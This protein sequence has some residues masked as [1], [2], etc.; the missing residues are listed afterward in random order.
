MLVRNRCCLPLQ[1]CEAP[2]AHGR[3]LPAHSDPQRHE[4]AVL[5]MVHRLQRRPALAEN[6]VVQILR[7]V[8]P[9]V[10]SR[11]AAR[12]RRI[13]VLPRA[14]AYTALLQPPMHSRSHCF[15][16]RLLLL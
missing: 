15:S 10:P 14:V 7:Q 2:F 6:V 16:L 12:L 11:Q 3:H 8:P 1:Q 13:S 5:Y 4:A 9:R